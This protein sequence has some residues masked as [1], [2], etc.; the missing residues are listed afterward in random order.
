[1]VRNELQIINGHILGMKF[2][3]I[4]YIENII[5]IEV[6]DTMIAKKI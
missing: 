2:L 6:L 4:K 1:M 3:N 5:D